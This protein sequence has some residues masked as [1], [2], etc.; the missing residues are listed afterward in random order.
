[1]QKITPFPMKTAA[2]K[3]PE[4]LMEVFTGNQN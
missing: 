4:Q 1:M 2:Q 3:H